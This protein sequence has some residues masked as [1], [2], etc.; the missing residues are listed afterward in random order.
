M[1]ERKEKCLI[2][3]GEF[4]NLFLKYSIKKNQYLLKI[5]SKIRNH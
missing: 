2:Y 5:K 3:F 4:I 1:I